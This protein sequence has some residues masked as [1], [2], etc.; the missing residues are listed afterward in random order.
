MK[1]VEL[2]KNN[3]ISLLDSDLMQELIVRAA[4][5]YDCI[6]LD[7]PPVVG[8][9]DLKILGKLADGLLLV[10]RPGVA[11]Y[12]SVDAAKKILETTKLNV[13]GVVANGVD[14][15]L[16]SDGNEAYFPDRKYMEAG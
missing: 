15:N 6:I 14:L 12:S 3:P 1:T 10:V 2:Y 8:L 5:F 11:R 4:G 16:E 9:A 13:L 7:T